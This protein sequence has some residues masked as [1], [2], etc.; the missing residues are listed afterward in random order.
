MNDKHITGQ[1]GGTSRDL[2]GQPSDNA[3][4]TGVEAGDGARAAAGDRPGFNEMVLFLAS[5]FTLIAA[6]PA[7]SR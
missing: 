6:G 2:T 4:V 7:S 1:S 5:F 3:V